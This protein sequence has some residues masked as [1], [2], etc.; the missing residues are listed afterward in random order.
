VRAFLAVSAARHAHAAHLSRLF[1]LHSVASNGAVMAQL[2][3][4]AGEQDDCEALLAYAFLL[5]LPPPPQKGAAPSGDAD[6][7]D[8]RPAPRPLAELDTEVAAYLSGLLAGGGGGGGGGGGSGGGGGAVSFD[9][10]VADAVAKLE[11]AGVARRWRD[12]AS[13]L[14]VVQA[15]SLHEALERLRGGG[16]GGGG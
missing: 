16:G 12:A 6:G 9:F 1:L 4:A 8:E 10:E 11:A 2:A 5:L 7:D 15:V 14:D 13:G 3:D